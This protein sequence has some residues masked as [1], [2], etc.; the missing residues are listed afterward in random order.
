M[1]GLFSPAW[2]TF[3]PKSHFPV[4]GNFVSSFPKIPKMTAKICTLVGI[5][6]LNGDEIIIKNNI[7][8]DFLFLFFDFFSADFTEHLSANFWNF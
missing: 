6:R 1:G 7:F 2:E 8:W 3:P 4:F 5:I